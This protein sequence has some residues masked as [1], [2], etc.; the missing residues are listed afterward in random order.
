[1]NYEKYI[2]EALQVVAAWEVPEEDFAR[3][4]NDQARI[5]AGMD[6]GPPGDLP[7]PS[8]CASLHF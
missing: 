7:D 6:L 4:V 3:A 2:A 1:M 8:P 5:M